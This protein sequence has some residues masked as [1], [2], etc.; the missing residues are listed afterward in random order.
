L[1]SISAEG[2]HNSGNLMIL[3]HTDNHNRYTQNTLHDL[4]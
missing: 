3:T 2:E 4:S 1:S